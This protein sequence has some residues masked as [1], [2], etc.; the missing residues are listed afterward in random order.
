ME[1]ARLA[2][3]SLRVEVVA[4]LGAMLA[5]VLSFGLVVVLFASASGEREVAVVKAPAA[6]AASAAAAVVEVV[7]RPK[8]G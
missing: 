7:R 6:A 5:S 3:L 4:V 2:G 1:A 8:P